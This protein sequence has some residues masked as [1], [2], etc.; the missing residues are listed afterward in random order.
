MKRVIDLDDVI[1]FK[2]LTEEMSRNKYDECWMDCLCRAG[3]FKK[4]KI[5]KHIATEHQH[6]PLIEPYVFYKGTQLGNVDLLEW[7]LNKWQN[8]MY[9]EPQ[10][11]ELYNE[12]IRTAIHWGHYDVFMR[13][14]D[15]DG[16]DLNKALLETVEWCRSEM[17]QE[18]LKRIHTLYK[19]E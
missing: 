7:M 5:F 8:S 2:R 6:V 13:Y 11:N 10:L 14:L 9:D 18:L 19:V 1:A 17:K 12:G 3:E 16:I 4:V 15:F